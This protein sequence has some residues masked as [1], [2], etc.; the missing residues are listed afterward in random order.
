MGIVAGKFVV[1]QTVVAAKATEQQPVIQE[2]TNQPVTEQPL[3]QY[4]KLKVGN[5]VNLNKFVKAAAAPS[6]SDA[7]KRLPAY[8]VI[9]KDSDYLNHHKN[10]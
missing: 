9:P 7:D 4:G 2:P 1:G 3:Q 10:S 5:F 8:F 6:V